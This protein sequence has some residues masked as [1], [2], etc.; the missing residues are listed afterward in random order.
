MLRNVD[1]AYDSGFAIGCVSVVLA[2][3]NN[4]DPLPAIALSF[5]AYLAGAILIRTKPGG[6]E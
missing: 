4:I 2:Y 1:F 3:M 5:L 6:K